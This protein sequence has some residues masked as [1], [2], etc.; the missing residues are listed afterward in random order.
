M[1]PLQI[2][3]VTKLCILNVFVL[4]SPHA[5]MRGNI[6]MWDVQLSDDHI[7]A[8]VQNSGDYWKGI[9][10]SSI[11]QKKETEKCPIQYVKNSLATAK[12]DPVFNCDQV[13]RSTPEMST[14]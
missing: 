4:K 13:T 2:R 8:A 14:Y 12:Y 1:I 3:P 9:S 6:R 10:R 7:M 11:G 5:D